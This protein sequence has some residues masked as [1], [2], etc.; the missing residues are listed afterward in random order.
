M[1]FKMLTKI[2]SCAVGLAVVIAS[3][4]YADQQDKLEVSVKAIS[5][6]SNKTSRSFVG[7]VAHKDVYQIVSHVSGLV[8]HASVTHGQVIED[9]AALYEIKILDPGFENALINNEFGKVKVI[10]T[11]IRQGQ[12]VEKNRT[13]AYVVPL[14]EYKIEVKMLPN[15]L[16]LLQ[17]GQTLISGELFPQTKYSQHFTLTDY[18][19]VSPIQSNPFYIVEFELNCRVLNCKGFE[20]SSA[21]AKVTVENTVNE[22]AEIPISYLRKGMKA[23]YVLN[24]EGVVE[25]THVDILKLDDQYARVKL[26]YGTHMNVIV[27]S[28]RIPN[29]GEKPSVV[30]E[31]L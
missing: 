15:E 12:F 23:V 29:D 22:V 13:L 30:K 10:Q 20:L 21:V 5:A 27:E 11:K 26:A 14:D 24:D 19:V 18:N 17:S 9:K 28:N 1:L 7:M 4:C 25:T 6:N 16:A 31:K 3:P 8:K 2:T